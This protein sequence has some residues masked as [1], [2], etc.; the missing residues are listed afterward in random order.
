MVKKDVVDFEN[1]TNCWLCD[2]GY[3]HGDVKVKDHC[4]VTRK[5]RGSSHRA[6][7]IKQG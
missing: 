1:F 3:V 7:N 2:N 5:Y 6:F 4:Q